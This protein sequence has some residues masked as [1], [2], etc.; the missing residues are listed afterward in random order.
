MMLIFQHFK[1]V[2]NMSLYKQKYKMLMYSPNIHIMHVN[3]SGLSH[4]KH[5]SI[6]KLGAY[7]TTFLINHIEK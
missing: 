5:N 4:L 1:L 3:N 6:N 2:Y 7:H